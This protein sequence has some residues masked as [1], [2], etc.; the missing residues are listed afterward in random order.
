MDKAN[1]KYKHPYMMHSTGIVTLRVTD[2]HTKFALHNIS[3][4]VTVWCLT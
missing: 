3:A 2:K 4:D 1:A